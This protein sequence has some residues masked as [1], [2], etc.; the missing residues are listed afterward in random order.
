MQLKKKSRNKKTYLM[1][2]QGSYANMKNYLT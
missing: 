2:Q 1:H